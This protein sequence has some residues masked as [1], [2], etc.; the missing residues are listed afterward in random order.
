MSGICGKVNFDGAPVDIQDIKCMAQAAMYR[1]PDGIN[2]WVKDNAG[3]AHLK[4]IVTPESLAEHQPVIRTS[5]TLV[6][7]ARIDN[8]QDL[9]KVLTTAG[10]LVQDQPS[11]PDILL[12]A[13][14]LWGTDCANHLIGDFAFAIWDAREQ[15]LYAARDR[16]G[17]KAFYFAFVGKAFF[18]ATE[19]NQILAVPG[20]SIRINEAMIA[21][22]LIA[23][24]YGGIHESYYQNIA[25]LGA[26]EQIVVTSSGYIIRQYWDLDPGYTI[27]YAREEEYAEHFLELFRQ[28]VR[29]RIRSVRPI[30]IL[31]S[32]GLDSTAVAALAASEL[33]TAPLE[34]TPSLQITTW[35][36]ER[37]PQHSE[38][39]RSRAVAERWNIPYHEINIDHMWSRHDY[40][41]LSPHPD[42]P[43]ES[44]LYGAFR[45]SFS[46]DFGSAKPSNWLSGLCGDTLIGG[47][48]PFYYYNFLK[49]GD[50]KG[51]WGSFSEHARAYQFSY[52]DL[53]YFSLKRLYSTYRLQFQHQ[54]NLQS[55]R[56][57]L[58]GWMYS[59]FI[60]RTDLRNWLIEKDRIDEQRVASWLA[61]DGSLEKLLRYKLVFRQSDVRMRVFI[62][63]MAA[64]YGAQSTSPFEDERLIKFCMAI[65][66]D[67][68]S[69]GLNHKLLLRKA[70]QAY[71]PD[72]VRE[73]RGR[74]IGGPYIPG[75]AMESFPEARERAIE[76]L[77]TSLADR[78]QMI[79][80]DVWLEKLHKH[81]GHQTLHGIDKVLAL[82]VWLRQVSNRA[83]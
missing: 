71:L 41:Q 31:M 74:R 30:G 79:K 80:K 70:M 6:A 69:E 68:I 40:P 58:P 36:T 15:R 62:E 10:R 35:D 64:G 42:E 66:E 44:H 83:H 54:H 27:R 67:L 11:D 22:D 14:E 47:I 3:F 26:A 18:L 16:M 73:R 55:S 17:N 57:S 20:F 72:K 49:R 48:N 65:P 82:E 59:D 21:H 43:Y 53:F 50:L 63:R 52:T 23:Q 61:R 78:M 5:L 7:D 32:G 76:L 60:K 2:H 45:A 8:R 77:E 34:L 39:E 19:A 33:A 28:S 37:W 25:A 75:L 81:S 51:F 13:Y 9:K 46:T 12:A 24:G 29:D 1:G 4:L 38:R 56:Y